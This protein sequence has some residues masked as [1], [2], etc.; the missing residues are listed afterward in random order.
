MTRA[1]IYNRCSTDMETQLSALETQ[2][3][4]SREIVANMGWELVRI[5]RWICS[6]YA[7]PFIVAVRH[8]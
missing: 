7:P 4:E 3:A 5:G 8:R 2:V 6:L 1:A